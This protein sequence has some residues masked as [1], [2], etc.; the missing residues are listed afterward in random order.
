MNNRAKNIA[1][2][3]K[4][5]PKKW[6]R[7]I[8]VMRPLVLVGLMGAGKSTVGRRIAGLIRVP[9]VDA[10]EAIVAA[11]GMDIPSIFERYGEPAFRDLEVKVIERLLLGPPLVLA[12]GGGAFMA[13]RLR[14]QVAQHGVSC[15]LRADL[16]TL[17][18]RVKDRPGRPLLAVED[19]KARLAALQQQRDP[20][21]AMA[22]L[23]VDTAEDSNSFATAKSVI[24]ALILRDR[25]GTER[26]FFTERDLSDSKNEQD[27]I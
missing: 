26:P 2:A 5:A 23:T 8:R 15:W 7:E 17:W 19:P 12:T 1:A 11:A 21:Y 9:F 14:E 16:D 20:V 13:Q 25:D 4:P 6:T 3:P 10:D 22:D 18:A 24:R 27:R